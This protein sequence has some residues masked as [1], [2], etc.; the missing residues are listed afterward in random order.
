MSG[1]FV[2]DIG[3]TN[4]KAR[5]LNEH[6]T[7]V[8]CSDLTNAPSYDGA[9][10]AIDVDALYEWLIDG[11]RRASRQGRIAAINVSTHGAAVV[12]LGESG[13][14]LLPVLDYEFDGLAGETDEYG[15]ARP[16]FSTTYSPALGAGLNVGRQLW[17]LRKTRAQT[18]ACLHCL[19]FLPQYFVWKLSGARVAELTSIGC[20]TD[21]WDFPNRRL[22]KLAEDLG[23]DDALPKIV[24]CTSPVSTLLP[25]VAKLTGVSD[26]CL[27]YPGVHDSNA[28]LARY[29]GSG[30]QPPFT[31]V[32]TGTWI[33]SMFV[34]GPLDLL[35]E[36]K[37]MLGNLS[38]MGTPIPCARFMGGRDFE[39]LCRLGGNEP[40]TPATIDHMQALVAEGIYAI[41]PFQAGSGPFAKRQNPSPIIGKL[42]Y[43]SAL[44]TL[45][46]ALMIDYELDLLRA[47]G[48]IL[49]GSMQS[50]NPLLCRLLAQLRPENEVSASVLPQ[51]DDTST[52]LGAWILTRWEQKM[53]DELSVFN[54]VEPSAIQGLTDYRETWRGFCHAD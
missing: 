33:V 9:Y 44:A 13:E 18:F 1:T 22:S 42:K 11:L 29:L 28:S 23:V 50:K 19:L 12:L 41:P 14:R 51:S 34:G 5:V 2:L 16:P 46:L 40:R 47:R 37:D 4:A 30:L 43:P 25:E 54:P 7:V 36:G 52:V 38:V 39:E 17:W 49:F 24:P 6:G 8:W 10:P 45:Y 53:P 27:V 15:A 3:K 31:V 21:L 20:H 48:R 26:E 35:E 32:S